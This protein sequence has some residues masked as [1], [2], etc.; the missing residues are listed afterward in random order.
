MNHDVNMGQRCKISSNK[1]RQDK[2]SV[3]GAIAGKPLAQIQWSPLEPFSHLRLDRIN[4]GMQGVY[5]IRY[6]DNPDQLNPASILYVA[7]AP[8]CIRSG[9]IADYTGQGNPFLPDFVHA[10]PS[11]IYFQYARCD[12]PRNAEVYLIRSLGYP[13]C[14]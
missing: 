8:Y 5:I 1:P 11:G 4:M 6:R 12:D 7:A 14:N 10:N 9:L 2:T 3:L 13:V